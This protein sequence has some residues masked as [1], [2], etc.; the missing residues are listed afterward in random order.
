MSIIAYAS[1][2]AGSTPGT[3]FPSPSTRCEQHGI[4]IG[5]CPACPLAQQVAISGPCPPWC[6]ADHSA[7]VDIEEAAA[8]RL[9]EHRVDAQGVDVHVTV[10]MAEDL[11]TGRR[12]D[13]EIRVETGQPMSPAAAGA[14]AAALDCALRLLAEAGE[15]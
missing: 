6:A 4:G 2:P 5:L 1:V 9:H 3:R 11:L 10:E 13:V 12:D 8:T 7:A 14:L 15:R